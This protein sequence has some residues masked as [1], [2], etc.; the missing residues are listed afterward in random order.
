MDSLHQLHKGVFKDHLVKWCIQVAPG[1]AAEIDC[2]FQLMPKHPILQHFTKGIS[3]LS[4]LTGTEHREMQKV[5]AGPLSGA[6]PKDIC[7][8]ARATLDFIYYA[9]FQSHTSE[10]LWHL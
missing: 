8:V 7:A 5:F 9:S 10:T 3:M 4:Q 1:G 2:Q 6:V